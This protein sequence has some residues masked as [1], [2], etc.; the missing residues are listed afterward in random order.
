LSGYR[1]NARRQA[2]NP[3]RKEVDI[4]RTKS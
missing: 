4:G 3:I 1:A 2:E